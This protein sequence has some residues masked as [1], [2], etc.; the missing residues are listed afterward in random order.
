MRWIVALLAAVALPAGE[1][2]FDYS[3]VK[4]EIVD[5]RLERL[6]DSTAKRM[7]VLREMFEQAGCTGG[8]LVEQAVRKQL[9]NV[10][11]ALG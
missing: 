11:C 8:S 1:K 5:E 3:T 6:P 4:R 2:G 10:I 7:A 9:P